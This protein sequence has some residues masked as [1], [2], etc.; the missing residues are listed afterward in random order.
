M[1]VLC[2]SVLGYRVLGANRC[3]PTLVHRGGGCTVTAHHQEGSCALSRPSGALQYCGAV[4]AH[5]TLVV[6]WPRTVKQSESWA[7]S[8][9]FMPCVL[10]MRP[11]KCFLSIHPSIR[12]SGKGVKKIIIFG[13]QNSP[14]FWVFSIL[15]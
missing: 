15:S 1:P 4:T 14:I 5:Q 3:R 12:F 10:G 8:L 7:L 6:A 9:R 13:G 2:C 11:P